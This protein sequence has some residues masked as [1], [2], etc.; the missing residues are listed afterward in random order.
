MGVLRGFPVFALVAVAVALVIALTGGTF[1]LE[2]F[3]VEVARA[4]RFGCTVS[5]GASL[6]SGLA[7]AA[8]SRVTGQ[9]V[10]LALGSMLLRVVVVALAGAA[11]VLLLELEARSFLLAVAV[12][13]LALLVVDTWYALFVVGTGSSGEPTGGR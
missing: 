7:V 4:W 13:Y 8:G 10:T 3:G 2:R 9:G 11:V 5:L 1:A 12:S 6:L